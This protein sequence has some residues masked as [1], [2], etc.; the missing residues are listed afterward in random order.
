[1]KNAFR[2]LFI[3]FS[4]ALPLVPSF[5]TELTAKVSRTSFEI[6][7]SV[8]Y[9]VEI[10]PVQSNSIY[11]GPWQGNWETPFVLLKSNPISDA[12]KVFKWSGIF[13]VLDT[14]HLSLPSFSISIING[15]DTLLLRTNPIPIVV[16][17]SLLPIV[18]NSQN[19]LDTLL[20]PDKS[21]K[22]IPPSV[23]E[24][25]LWI[26]TPISLVLLYFLFKKYMNYRKSLLPPPPPLPPPSPEE[27]FQKRIAEIN[28]EAKWQLGDIKGF[29]SD[30]V[31]CIKIYIDN[32]FSLQTLESTTTELK[33]KKIIEVLGE[34]EHSIL[35]G[36][37]DIADEVKFAKGNI[38]EERCKQALLDAN[39]IVQVWYLRVDRQKI[40]KEQILIDELS[41]V[42]PS[43]SV[44]EKDNSKL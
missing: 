29:V 34:S 25:L 41:K 2:I 39:N 19:G 8:T 22:T 4:F 42:V 1:M 30:L 13:T 11:N 21:P 26:G 16:I 17:G 33:D 3:I 20:S 14:G 18:Q 6:G 40:T 36:M 27:V 10:R 31:E 23:W 37:F 12:E 44:E 7:D 35:I 32:K 38:A 24:W 9:S 43:P 5:A 15:V 28:D